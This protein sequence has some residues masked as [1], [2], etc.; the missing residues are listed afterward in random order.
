MKKKGKKIKIGR[1]K[2]NKEGMKTSK[3]E[4]YISRV[5][6]RADNMS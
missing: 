1:K 6:S 4:N 2:I 3:R 5:V